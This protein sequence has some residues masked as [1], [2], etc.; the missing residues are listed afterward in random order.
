MPFIAK[1][2]EKGVAPDSTALAGGPFDTKAQVRS[3]I[4]LHPLQGLF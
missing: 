1:L 4:V 2:R 3:T